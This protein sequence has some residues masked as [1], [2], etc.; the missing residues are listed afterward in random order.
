M[1]AVKSA[2]SRFQYLQ[3]LSLDGRIPDQLRLIDSPIVAQDAAIQSCAHCLLQCQNASVEV[4]ARAFRSRPVSAEWLCVT[5][6]PICR[7]VW[8]VAV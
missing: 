1:Q 2:C 5:V 6:R 7:R 3:D 8:L 4:G